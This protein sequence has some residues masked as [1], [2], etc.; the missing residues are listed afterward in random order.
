VH[1]AGEE[2]AAGNV[3]DATLAL[4]EARAIDQAIFRRHLK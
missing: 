1:V 4:E 2:L 3:Y